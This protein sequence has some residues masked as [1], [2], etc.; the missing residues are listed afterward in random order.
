VL[1]KAG[2]FGGGAQETLKK[3]II[4]FNIDISHFTG[5]L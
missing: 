1:R 5:K 3:K 4:E 2:R